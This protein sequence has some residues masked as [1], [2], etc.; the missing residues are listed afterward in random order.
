MLMRFNAGR[1]LL[2]AVTWTPALIQVLTETHKNSFT[3]ILREYNFSDSNVTK[4]LKAGIEES[5]S[6]QRTEAFP[7]QRLDKQLFS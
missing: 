3:F 6:R 5:L 7:L 4:C 2:I 1:F